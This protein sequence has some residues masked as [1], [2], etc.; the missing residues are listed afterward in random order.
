MLALLLSILAPHAATAQGPT[1]EPRAELMESASEA[2]RAAIPDVFYQRLRMLT[3]MG[4]PKR[5]K[6][7]SLWQTEVC[8][9]ET[10][11]PS[12]GF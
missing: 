12:R 1:A 9:D 11:P 2:A 7:E 10:H 5:A 4:F 3:R 6:S 8:H